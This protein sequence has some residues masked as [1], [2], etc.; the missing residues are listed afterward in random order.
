MSW[1]TGT[2]TNFKD[3]LEQVKD[4]AEDEGWTVNAYSTG[5]GAP[6]TDSVYLTGPGYGT[7]YEC[8][9]GIRTYE[10]AANNHYCFELRGATGYDGAQTWDTQ[11]GR[12]PNIVVMRLW[13][14]SI[15]YWLSVTDRRIVLIAKCSNTYHSLYAGFFNPFANPVEYP[16]PMYIAA[17]AGSY[18]PF[19]NTDT[20]VRA[21]A[22]PGRLGAYLRDPAGNWRAVCVHNSAG[23][24][25]FQQSRQNVFTIWPYLALVSGAD[26][27]TNQYDRLPYARIE[28]LPGVSDSL[29]MLNCYITGMDDEHGVLGVLEG[30][31]WIPGNTLSAEQELTVGADSYRVFIAISRS[32][33]S[34]SQFYAVKEG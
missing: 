33:E 20:D 10:D 34:P 5:G 7:G 8:Y 12:S 29:F 1:T 16:Y 18:G 11:P 28:P 2:A 25:N 21:V 15:N 13:N 30:L 17:D 26:N 24:Y 14:G 23:D 9:V 27:P 19:G 22:F 31:Y 6:R 3:L 4:F 32:L